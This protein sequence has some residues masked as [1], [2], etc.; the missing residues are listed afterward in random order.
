MYYIVFILPAGRYVVV[1]ENWI[2]DI[3]LHMEKFLNNS[4]NS[5]QKYICYWS[6]SAAAR[7]INGILRID[8]PPDFDSV[9]S[10]LFPAEGCYICHITKAKC[11]LVE[12]IV[13]MNV[14]SS[15][16]WSLSE[17]LN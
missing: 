2:K 8:F 16:H 14:Q 11:K 4:L 13:T 15:V 3:G 17:A 10:P 9:F 1:P 5:S 7:D 6:N 12:E